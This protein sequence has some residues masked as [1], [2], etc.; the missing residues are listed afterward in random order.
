MVFWKSKSV[1]CIFKTSPPEGLCIVR[2]NCPNCSHCRSCVTKIVP[3]SSQPHVVHAP[4]AVTRAVHP[5]LDVKLLYELCEFC[6]CVYTE[7]SPDYSTSKSWFFN[8]RS[9]WIVLRSNCPRQWGSMYCWTKT[10]NSFCSVLVRRSGRT[11]HHKS[12]V[13]PPLY[14]WT[15][16]ILQLTIVDP[17]W[18]C[19]LCCHKPHIWQ[20]TKIFSGVWQVASSKLLALTLALRAQSPTS[21]GCANPVQQ[22]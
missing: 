21:F 16:D 3:F 8:Q 10:L 19:L 22:N 15:S 17:L 4:L 5:L 1:A 2:P 18:S 13:P 12:L 6:G 20:N 11:S 7:N 9:A 14:L